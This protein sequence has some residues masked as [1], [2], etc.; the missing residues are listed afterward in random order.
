MFLSLSLSST[1]FM[2]FLAEKLAFLTRY[3]PRN[4]ESFKFLFEVFGVMIFTSNCGV[5]PSM[6]LKIN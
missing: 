2:L 5:V 6:N 1:T 3:L 4:I